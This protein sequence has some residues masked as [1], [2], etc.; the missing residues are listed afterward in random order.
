MTHLPYSTTAPKPGDTLTAAEA[1]ALPVGSQ[2]KHR[3]DG[4]IMERKDGLYWHMILDGHTLIRVGP[5]QAAN[6]H[7][8]GSLAWA[9][10]AAEKEGVCVRADG[11]VWAWRHGQM[12]YWCISRDWAKANPWSEVDTPT[13]WSIVPDPSAV[14]TSVDTPICIDG[15]AIYDALDNHCGDWR[16]H[17]NVAQAIDDLGKAYSV[18]QGV[19]AF[20]DQAVEAELDE[21]IPAWRKNGWAFAQAIRELG[22]HARMHQAQVALNVET[23]DDRFAALT[24]QMVEL[25]AERDA[26]KGELASMTADR[27]NH[28]RTCAYQGESAAASAKYTKRLEGELA[29]L[30][31]VHEKCHEERNEARAERDTLRTENIALC[32][33]LASM[34]V[35]RDAAISEIGKS[36]AIM[37]M[38]QAEEIKDLTTKRDAALQRAEKAEQ[39]WQDAFR[40]QGETLNE[41]Q[42]MKDEL[43]SV[44]AALDAL[45]AE[46]RTPQVQSAHPEGSREW[47]EDAMQQGFS[48]TNDDPTEVSYVPY[49]MGHI[50][51]NVDGEDK[52]RC[53]PP[54]GW[55]IHT[56]A[57]APSPLPSIAQLDERLT[58]VERKLAALAEGATG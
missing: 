44:S 48:V 54:A 38:A 35:Q 6:P 5:E 3:D 28:M 10:W 30:A 19:E 4:H 25:K 24:A 46:T 55:R 50:F 31:E 32:G 47:A 2:L 21:A 41:M 14:E 23:S 45:R 57:V 43:A 15:A 1:N 53:L 51:V 22:L 36:C 40:K 11:A 56:P 49:R 16:S 27:D 13:G 29:G 39:D 7:A 9:R 42:A 33:K 17:G 20:S 26:L 52:W 58:K 37:A 18:L 8:V 12:K 34:G